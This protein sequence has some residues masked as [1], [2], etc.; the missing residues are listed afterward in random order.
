MLAGC[1][2][3][4]FCAFLQIV[5]FVCVICGKTLS[6]LCSDPLILCGCRISVFYKFLGQRKFENTFEKKVKL[7]IFQLSKARIFKVFHNIHKV[8]NADMNR[9]NNGHLKESNDADLQSVSSRIP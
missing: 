6:E 1:S 7:I 2:Y 4:K 5:F 3:L 8:E 9:S